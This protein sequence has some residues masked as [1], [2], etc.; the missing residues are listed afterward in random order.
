[1][2]WT[3]GQVLVIISRE[4]LIALL[5]SI[6]AINSCSSIFSYVKCNSL[7]YLSWIDLYAICICYKL[8]VIIFLPPIPPV[9][10]EDS[11]LQ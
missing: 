9:D 1:M 5:N 2:E 3:G 4:F 10:N 7:I 8:Y 11:R 6:N